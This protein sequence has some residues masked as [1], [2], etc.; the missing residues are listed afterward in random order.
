MK[1]YILLLGCF[2][3]AIV[4]LGF[5]ANSINTKENEKKEL[6]K[7]NAEITNPTFSSE[8]QR[9]FPRE[10]DS[11]KKTKENK[12]VEDMLKKWPQLSIVWAGYPFSKDYNAPRGHYYAVQDN[13]NT[14]RVA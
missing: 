2:V 8:W 4:V 1:K 13:V 9:Y 14:L 3:A 6:A 11:W 7:T 5:L 12:R 10:Y